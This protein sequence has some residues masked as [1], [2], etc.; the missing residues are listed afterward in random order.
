[1]KK[2]YLN[3]NQYV[4]NNGEAVIM[5]VGNQLEES[6]EMSAILTIVAA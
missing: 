1:M 2:Q 6:N 3:G 4:A 5:T